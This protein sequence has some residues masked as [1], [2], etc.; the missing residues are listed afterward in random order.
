MDV[1]TVQAIQ[2]AGLTDWSK[3]GTALHARFLVGSFAEAVAFAQEVA[4]ISAGHDP[5]VRMTA[6]FVDLR[7][8]TP[9]SVYRQEGRPD[10]I[11][12]SVTQL[13]IDLAR[14]ISALAAARGL[15]ADQEGNFE[16]ELGLDTADAAEIGP[17]WAALLTGD[18]ANYD[19]PEVVDPTGRAPSLWFQKTSA[20][21]A[22]RQRFH[23][24]LWMPIALA[25]ARIKAAVA[26]G[27]T[28]TDDSD[29]SF[30]VLSDAQGNRACICTIEGR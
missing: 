12:S 11:W 28:V 13:D 4:E 21:E 27:G 9:G 16:A 6:T 30:T 20:H 23:F 29:P 24:D 3:L 1:L 25:P 7:L 5:E 10:R 15:Q 22:P 18:A 19:H 2:D 26:A 17:F 14:E 8:L